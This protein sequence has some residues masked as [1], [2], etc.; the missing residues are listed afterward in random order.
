MSKTQSKPYLE[1][2]CYDELDYSQLQQNVFKALELGATGISVPSIHMASISK[3]M[4]EGIVLTCPV[5]Y[6]DGYL[7][8]QQRL[9]ESKR[10]FNSGANAIDLV[11][12][13]PLLK[14]GR[15]D[16]FL[17]D[18]QNHSKLCDDNNATLRIIA[19][20]RHFSLREYKELFR[21][22]Q[23]AYI[24]YVLCSNGRYVVDVTDDLI[25]CTWMQDEFGIKTIISGNLY[26]KHD[27]KDIIRNDVFGIR[28]NN[29]N[30]M[31]N[32]LDGV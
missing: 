12:S 15:E 4:P 26:L 23:K 29:I 10:A 27:Y 30:A 31:S 14:N 11:I 19:D 2:A 25:T 9:S 20:Y 18:L 17:T 21:I 13:Y 16:D 3:F 5:D 22:L 1:Y 6:P 24:E 32:C 7:H 28:F 8:S